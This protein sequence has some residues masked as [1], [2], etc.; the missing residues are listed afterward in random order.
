LRKLPQGSASFLQHSQ[1][2]NDTIRES[3]EAALGTGYTL[4]RELGGGGMSRVWT[5]HDVTLGREVVVKLLSPDLAHDLSAER[6]TRE[7]RLAAALQHAHIVPL[8]TAGVTGDG[9]P[10]YLMPFV[11]G[12]S[13]RAKLERPEFSRGLPIDEVVSV[14]RD[15]CRALAYAHARGVVHRD[16]KPDNILV[17]GGSAVVA[18]FGI[19]KA[20]TS[21]RASDTQTNAALTRVGT[22]IGSPAYMSPEQGSGDP[23]TDH[24]TDIYAL[25]VTAYELLTGAPPFTQ[26][27]STGL[28]MAHFTETPK[29]VQEQRADIPDALAALVM[30]CLE[31][32]PDARPQS[33]E[34]LASELGA[35]GTISGT[36][37]ATRNAQ[38]QAGAAQPSRPASRRTALVAGGIAAALAIGVGAF[39]YLRTPS[40]LESNLVAVM[41][42]TVRDSSVQLWREGLVDILSRSLDGA[43]TLRTVA[44]S[45]SIGKSPARAD[46]AEAEKL[47]RALGAGLVVFGDVGV[48]GR[49]SV[50]VR[51]TVYDVARARPRNSFDARGERTRMEALADSIALRVLRELGGASGAGGSPLT[52]VGTRSV[53]AMRAFLQ[54]QQLYRRA[55]IDSARSAYLAALESDSTF[56]LAWRGVA[57][58]FI[59]QGRENEPDAVRA[60]EMAIR[61]KSGRSPRDS[62]LLQADSLRLA[63][64][65]RTPGATDPVDVIPSL[66]LLFAAWQRAT[67]AYP[68]DA[69][70]WFERGDAAFHFG[71]RAGVTH[72]ESAEWFRRGLALDS[73]F[74]V[75]YF[76]LFELAIREGNPSQAAQ[77]VRRMAAL[78]SGEVASYYLLLATIL[79]TQPLSDATRKVLDTLP[80]RYVAGVL[81][82]MA[83]MPDSGGIA[84]Q[85]AKS[86][87]QRPLPRLTTDGDSTALRE[88]LARVLAGRGHGRDA[89][90]VSSSPS[91]MLQLARTP[92]LS[93]DSALVRARQLLST[94]ARQAVSALRL[95]A[96]QRDTASIRQLVAW[97]D[98][99]DKAASVGGPKA[100]SAYTPMVLVYRALAAG[101]SAGALQAL[102]RIPMSVCDGAPCASST[103]ATLLLRKGR[104]VEAARV[105]DRALPSATFMSRVD[106]PLDWMLR[107]TLAEQLGDP[108]TASVYYRRVMNVLRGSD[109]EL[110]SV[111]SEATAGLQRTSRR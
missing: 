103:L 12:E 97:A 90:S 46:A 31:K 44:A 111:V 89:R 28:L 35:S 91:L 68:S 60:L 48:E 69:E 106:L 67:A 76:H 98:S 86:F 34:L 17:S 73:T 83:D 33:A 56:A 54:A 59:R 104:A 22:A 25:G 4:G 49:D 27:T 100:P 8:L 43:G 94:D 57:A 39:M 72:A 40:G 14:L 38:P 109:P 62:M 79:E 52:S 108:A 16:I 10:Y 105:L 15:V 99:T 51:Y 9:R 71:P 32:S 37:S 21:A 50:H 30:R 42:F 84:L 74:L 65:S 47:G 107:A 19:A 55:A 41:P 85:L 95:F 101:D 58:V 81:G 110:R 20:M 5:A 82:Q 96:D 29:P 87:L 75:P 36:V 6:F 102:L 11:E 61:Y 7:V 64:R 2:V 78:Q 66:T 18:D 1:Y 23:D 93:P 63:F 3:L 45:T 70:F 80:L 77:Y 24:R 13:L 53:P 26:P 88:Y 92:M